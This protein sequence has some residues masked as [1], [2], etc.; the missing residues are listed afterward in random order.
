MGSA[1]GVGSGACGVRL[2]PL[3]PAGS[4]VVLLFT[5]LL[6]LLISRS[7]RASAQLR[8]PSHRI[9]DDDL[10]LAQAPGRR[11]SRRRRRAPIAVAARGW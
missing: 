6:L 11:A 7:S 2:P 3:R 1:A 8:H 10:T 5:L 4:R 9:G